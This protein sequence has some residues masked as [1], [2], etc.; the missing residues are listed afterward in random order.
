MQEGRPTS[1]TD[2]DEPQAAWRRLANPLLSH[3]RRDGVL[4][5]ACSGGGVP[6]R[7]GR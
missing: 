7:F 6:T 1:Q 2:F 5:A 3:R 4:P